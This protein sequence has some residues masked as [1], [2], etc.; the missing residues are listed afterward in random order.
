MAHF[1]NAFTEHLLMN[2][3]MQENDFLIWDQLSY[4]I[5]YPFQKANVFSC[6]VW[7]PV[8]GHSGKNVKTQFLALPHTY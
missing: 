7:A 2:N 6:Q 3:A 5:L 8:S 1:Q 4:L